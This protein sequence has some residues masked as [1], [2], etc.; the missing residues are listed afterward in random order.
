MRFQFQNR[1][2]EHHFVSRRSRLLILW[3]PKLFL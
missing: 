2:L 3:C 1:K